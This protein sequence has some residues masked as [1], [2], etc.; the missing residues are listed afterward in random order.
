MKKLFW[1][2]VALTSAFVSLL[3]GVSEA[4]RYLNHN[5]ALLRG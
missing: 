3:P 1:A 2:I 5:Q 4:G